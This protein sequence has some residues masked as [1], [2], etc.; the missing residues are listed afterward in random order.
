MKKIQPIKSSLSNMIIVLVLVAGL[1]ALILGA[2]YK[3]T[4]GPIQKAK[5]NRE[6]EAIKEVVYGDFSNN[7][8]AERHLIPT[9]DG[10]GKVE[11]FP[12]RNADGNITSVAIKTYSNNGFGGKIELMVGYFVDGTVNKYKVIDYKETPGLGTKVS[13]PKFS[14]QF[15]G[16]N[17]GKHVFK[18]KQDGGD[19]D[20]V[21]AAT[22][23]SRAV[24]DAIQRGYDAFNKLS[25][26]N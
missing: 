9:A 20:A 15:S 16:I 25:T 12:A 4:E 10:K 19:I 24:I 2:V 14:D 6:L 22:I 7:P 23:S 1:S 21:T 5:D 26:G 11:L 8:F 3:L 17:P 13:E 18:V